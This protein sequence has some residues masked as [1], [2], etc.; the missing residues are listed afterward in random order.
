LRWVREAGYPEKKKESLKG[1]GRRDPSKG[2]G[3]EKSKPWGVSTTYGCKK[4]AFWDRENR[5]CGKKI[6]RASRRKI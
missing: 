4:K 5:G 6:K 3:I 2:K 1:G